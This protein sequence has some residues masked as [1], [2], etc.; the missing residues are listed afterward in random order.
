MEY[1]LIMDSIKNLDIYRDIQVHV[2][3]KADLQQAGANDEIISIYT[4][5]IVDLKEE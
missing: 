2:E 3:K 4:Y 5:T 1:S